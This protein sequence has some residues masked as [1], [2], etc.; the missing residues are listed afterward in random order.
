MRTTTIQLDIE[1]KEALEK[2]KM[3][4]RETYNEIIERLLE[5][6]QELNEETERD[7]KQAL[8]DFKDGRFKTHEQLKKEM[9]F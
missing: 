4:P 9:G 8:K 2:M 5:D 7:I 6:T 3:Y 1:T